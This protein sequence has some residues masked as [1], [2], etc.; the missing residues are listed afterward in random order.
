[1]TTK[2]TPAQRVEQLRTELAEHA[3]RYHVLDAP[4]IPDADYDKL[5]RELRDLEDAH[6]ELQSDD[7]PTRRVGYAGDRQFASVAHAVPMLSL[8]NA[9]EPQEIADFVARI[10]KETGD[11][12][13]EFSVEPKLDGLAISLRYEDGRFVAGATRGD[14]ATGEDVTANLRTVRAIPLKLRGKRPPPVLEVRGEVYMPRAG[15]V[16]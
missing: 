6:P 15:F 3:Y 11:E 16:I 5:E 9:F 13:P 14:G 10:G 2:R 1:M 12:N 7:S 8:N 4:T